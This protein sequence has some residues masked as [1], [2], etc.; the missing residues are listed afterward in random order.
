MAKFKAGQG[1]G[2]AGM[3][4]GAMRGRGAGGS[5]ALRAVILC[6][7]KH[8]KTILR[9]GLITQCS[10]GC[11]GH[12]WYWEGFGLLEGLMLLGGLVVPGGISVTCG[13]T[14]VTGGGLV[15]SRF[16]G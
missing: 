14:G 15:L 3:L 16:Y 2:R 13:E 5:G 1:A 4:M 7:C 6:G 9:R 10:K 12:W 8:P 11:W